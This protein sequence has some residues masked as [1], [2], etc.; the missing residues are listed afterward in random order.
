MNSDWSLPSGTLSHKTTAARK[1]ATPH[2]IATAPKA[3][4]KTKNSLDR[5]TPKRDNGKWYV[6]N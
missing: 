4:T 5:D 2:P 6:T 3:K 1:M